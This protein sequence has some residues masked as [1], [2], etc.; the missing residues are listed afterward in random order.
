MRPHDRGSSE[1]AADSTYTARIAIISDE[2]GW[3]TAE[4]K[5]EAMT[6]RASPLSQPLITAL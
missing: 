4:R 2:L 5:Q 6:E 1:P 3:V